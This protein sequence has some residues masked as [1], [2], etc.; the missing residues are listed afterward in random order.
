LFYRFF[1]QQPNRPAGAALGRV[2]AHHG[3]DPLFPL[4]VQYFGGDG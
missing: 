3:D 4:V 2:G 1:A